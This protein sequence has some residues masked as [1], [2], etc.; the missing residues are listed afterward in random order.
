MYQEN[1]NIL[2]ILDSSL[3][4]KSNVHNLIFSHSP[5]Y[6]TTG[7]IDNPDTFINFFK[8]MDIRVPNTL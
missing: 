6:V 2:Y 7:P 1:V 3:E 8:D 4:I 5:Q